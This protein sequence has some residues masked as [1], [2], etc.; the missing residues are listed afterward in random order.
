MSATEE[1][2]AL[3]S[4]RLLCFITTA[5]RT[6]NMAALQLIRLY[7]ITGTYLYVTIEEALRE[8]GGEGLVYF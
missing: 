4:S 2:T 6:D 1:T 3:A 7:L 5:E 8:T